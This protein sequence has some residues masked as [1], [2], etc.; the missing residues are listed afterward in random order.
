MKMQRDSLGMSVVNVFLSRS[1]LT[2]ESC[3]R[4]HEV[5]RALNLLPEVLHAH[6]G[7]RVAI[8]ARHRCH[9]W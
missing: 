6:Y 1:E 5:M 3:L 7:M 8:P 2:R 4:N 9:D